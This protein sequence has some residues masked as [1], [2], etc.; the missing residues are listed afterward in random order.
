MK[1]IMVIDDDET[2]AF[3][4]VRIIKRC[5]GFTIQN[6]FNGGEEALGFLAKHATNENALPDILFIDVEMPFING[7][8]LC[9]AYARLK[10]AI[11]K[12]IDIYLCSC[13]NCIDEISRARSLASVEDYIIKPVTMQTMEALDMKY[14]FLC[15]E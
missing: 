2:F 13:S 10:P 15:K 1:K 14:N 7:W 6:I 12:K 5:S 4:F 9:E 3:L 8:E 11:T